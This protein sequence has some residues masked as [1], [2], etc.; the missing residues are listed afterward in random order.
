M[1]TFFTLSLFVCSLYSFA[2]EQKVSLPEF[3]KLEVQAQGHITITQ[4]ESN[5]L[6][7]NSSD[8]SKKMRWEVKNG[9]LYISSPENMDMY[10][11]FRQLNALRVNG[12]GHIVSK[13]RI[14]SDKLQAEL[15]GTGEININIEANELKASISGA[16][17]LQLSGEVN[18]STFGI[19]GVGKVAASQLKCKNC[20]VDISGAGSAQVSCSD[21][22]LTNISGIG[23]VKYDEKPA[24]IKENISGLGNVN[25]NEND[26]KKEGT[27][28]TIGDNNVV[29]TQSGDSLKR[30]T[31]FRKKASGNW[32]GLDLGFNGYMNSSNSSKLPAGY[33]FLELIPEKSVAV[34]LN[35]Y[36]KNFRL[37]KNY[38]VLTTGMGLSYNNYR[39]R[40]NMSLRADT[41]RIWYVNDSIDY[42]KNK[43]TVSYLTVPLLVT[44]NSSTK[45]SKSLHVTTGLL[46][47]YKL[48]SHTKQVYNSNGDRKKDKNYDDFNLETLRYDATLRLGYGHYTL[49]ANYA[50]SNLFKSGEGPTLHP[51]TVGIQLLSW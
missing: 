23:K 37:Y 47:S 1:K 51:W 32:G 21:S 22:L 34:N 28:F 49:F 25:N 19:S 15:S 14:K 2:Q 16:G 39:F 40:K 42:Q 44:F 27:R 7:Y 29:I 12:T 38:V 4:G 9:I 10:I 5:E 20:L 24:Y 3:D 11:Q 26:H 36:E 48:G 43:L 30:K 17:K 45:A 13:G 6:T 18:K 46:F 41:S 8:E 50:L 35:L 33:D 31:K